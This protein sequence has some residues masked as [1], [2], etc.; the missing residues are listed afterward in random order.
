MIEKAHGINKKSKNLNQSNKQTNKSS[1]G[2]SF[3]ILLN[4]VLCYVF[5]IKS[6]SI[7]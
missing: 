5:K 3:K 4:F 7:F 6:L 2:A 1:I